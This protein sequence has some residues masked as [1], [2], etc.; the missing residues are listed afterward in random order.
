MRTHEGCP[1]CTLAGGVCCG[2]VSEASK[3][4]VLSRHAK[5]GWF[6]TSDGWRPANSARYAASGLAVALDRGLE[7]GFSLTQL[8]LTGFDPSIESSTQLHGMSLLVKNAS[9]TSALI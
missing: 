3:S 5:Y 1:S 2:L 8:D 7:F 9:A 4:I 6:Q